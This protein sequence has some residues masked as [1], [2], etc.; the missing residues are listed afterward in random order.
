[1]APGRF[2]E[3]TIFLAAAVL[4]GSVQAQ[5][6]Q[7]PTKNRRLLSNPAAFYM[8]TDRYVDGVNTKPWRGGMYGYS[9][10]PRVISGN[11]VYARFHEGI[12]IGPVARDE[13]GEPLDEVL[14]IA[15]GR[16][17]H[18]NDTPGASNYGRYV[19]VEH[20]FPS[21]RF[22]SL[23]AHLNAATVKVGQRL[24]AG[25]RLGRLGYTGRGIDKRRAHL[26]LE[27]NLMLH[28]KFDEWYGSKY[29]E[30]NKHTLYN[31][32]NL[33]GLDVATLYRSQ[34]RG[35][36]YR[37]KDYVSRMRPYFKVAVPNTGKMDLIR[38]YPWLWKS[39]SRQAATYEMTLS[40]SGV[41]LAVRAKG[42]KPSKVPVLTWVKPSTSP[43]SWHTRRR[44][45]GSGATAKLTSSGTRYIELLAG[46]F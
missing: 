7:F 43:H 41:P 18:V 42:V 15:P 35:R 33:A 8:Y 5:K 10:N 46:M 17:V 21:G 27:L 45:T 19:V 13:K 34:A 29:E 30:A 22:Y 20:Q 16:V 6:I 26:H 4:T 39:G 12:D 36:V 11:T 32:I 14:S 1:M 3:G 24:R 31:G 9:R 44:L 25:S 2:L 23:Y 38:R 28:G 40:S 37:M